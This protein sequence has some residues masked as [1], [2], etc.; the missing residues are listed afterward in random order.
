VLTLKRFIRKVQVFTSKRWWRTLEAIVFGAAFIAV[1]INHFLDPEFFEAIVPRWF[2]SPSFANEVSGAAEIF[3]GAALI[4][5]WS[6][7]YAAYGLLILLVLVY[8]ANIDMFINDVDVVTNEFGKSVRVENA[9]GV[10]ARNLIRLPFQFLFAWLLWRH[11]KV[12]P[13]KK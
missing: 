1:G 2:W 5:I 3:L 12:N 8:P 9:S 13:E 7:R 10:F 6:R 4:P 11:T